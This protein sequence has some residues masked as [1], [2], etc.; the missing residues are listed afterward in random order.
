MP[1]L[2]GLV[3]VLDLCVKVHLHRE[4]AESGERWQDSGKRIDPEYTVGRQ[5]WLQTLPGCGPV[6]HFLMV[7]E[8]QRLAKEATNK[9]DSIESEAQTAVTKVAELFCS[10]A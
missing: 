6:P 10:K 5:C 1:R 7:Q 8:L 2:A 4:V 9:Q 3:A